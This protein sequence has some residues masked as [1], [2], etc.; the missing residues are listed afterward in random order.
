MRAH[1]ILALVLCVVGSHLITF[2]ATRQ[3]TTRY[4]L[5]RAEARMAAALRNAG[6]YEQLYPEGRARSVDLQL[7]IPMAGGMYYWWNDAVAYWGTGFIIVLSG[8]AVSRYAP[9]HRSHG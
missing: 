9:R 4:V 3:W 1:H 6:V 2:G 5:T 7:A 8:L